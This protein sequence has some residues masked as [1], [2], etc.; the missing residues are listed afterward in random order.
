MGQET[1]DVDGGEGADYDAVELQARHYIGARIL[2]HIGGFTQTQEDIAGMA[3]EDPPAY[4][5]LMDKVDAYMRTGTLRP[6]V[7]G[8]VSVPGQ[9]LPVGRMAV[10]TIAR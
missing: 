9:R 1:F 2:E 5:E 7:E 8:D 4:T 6:K 3:A 10:Q